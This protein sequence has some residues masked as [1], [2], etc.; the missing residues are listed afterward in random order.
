MTPHPFESHENI[1][2]TLNI[3]EAYNDALFDYL[4]DMSSQIEDFAQSAG[5]QTTYLRS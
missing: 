5:G 4:W 2:R 1:A 3:T